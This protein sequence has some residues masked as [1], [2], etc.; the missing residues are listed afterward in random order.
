[1]NY[2]HRY[3]KITRKE[4]INLG[5]GRYH[6]EN[7][8]CKYGHMGWRFIS[9]GCCNCTSGHVKLTNRRKKYGANENKM[10]ENDRLKF[11]RDLQKELDDYWRVE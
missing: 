3:K 1:M 4:A 10:L 2:Q 9:G 11:E 6:D 5:Q 7:Y 8:I